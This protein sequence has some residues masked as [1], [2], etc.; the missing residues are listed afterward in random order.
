MKI[1][2]DEIPVGAIRSKEEALALIAR[3]PVTIYRVNKGFVSISKREI[4]SHCVVFNNRLTYQRGAF[5]DRIGISLDSQN[6]FIFI[7]YWLAWGY[8]RRLMAQSEL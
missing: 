8:Y 5:Y 3:A 4:R 6:A 1:F 7:N 2:D